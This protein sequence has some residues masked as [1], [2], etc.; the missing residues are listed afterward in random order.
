MNSLWKQNITKQKTARPTKAK[1]NKT[2]SK[3]ATTNQPYNSTHKKAPNPGIM[4]YILYLYYELYFPKL[5]DR[6]EKNKP[7]K[8]QE[9]IVICYSVWTV[10]IGPDGI[11]PR[12]LKELVEVIAKLLFTIYQQSWPTREVP[13]AWILADVKPIY[14]KSQK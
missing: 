12:V 2:K 8:T 10:L 9:E 5:G 4:T 7:L 6:D 11:H 14:K 1:Q 3:Q 13:D